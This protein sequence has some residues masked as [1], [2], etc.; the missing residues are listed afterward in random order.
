[1]RHIGKRGSSMRIGTRG[2][3]LVMIALFSMM[4][5]PALAWVSC[6]DANTR[7]GTRACQHRGTHTY[8]YPCA[9]TDAH[10]LYGHLDQ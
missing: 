10:L 5:A 8:W 1:M 3:M 4:L 2:A 6:R 7:S 9:R